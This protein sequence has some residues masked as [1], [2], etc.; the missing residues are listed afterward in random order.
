MQQ[1]LVKNYMSVNVVTVEPDTSLPEASRVMKDKGFRR[2]PVV[3]GGK[4]LGIVSLSDVHEAEPSDATSLTVWE[5]TYLLSNLKVEK[6]MS[7][8]PVTVHDTATLG[9]VAKIML[10][11]KIGGIPVV[12]AANQLIGIITES[13]V[14]RAVVAEWDKT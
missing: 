7:S 4:L 2:L 5:L 3:K 13:D 11:K 8:N 9:D 6:I 1:H 12:D 10:E 14:F